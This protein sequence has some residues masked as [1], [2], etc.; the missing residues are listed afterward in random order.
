MEILDTAYALLASRARSVAELRDRLSRKGHP[1]EAVDACVLEL[2][3]RGYLDDAAFAE[4]F[5]RERVRLRPKGRRALLAE[6]RA[7][8]VAADIARVA[9]ERAWA[10]EEVDEAAL[11]LRAARA[12]ARRSLGGI[13]APPAG[14]QRLRLRHCLHAH[15]A[16]RGF[17]IE[18][19]R[20][21]AEDVLS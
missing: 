18:A 7:K 11:A 6:L 17:T 5:V 21:A 4:S 19:A 10:E 3:R 8:G 1:D 14:D 16:R 9:V 13:A 15:L 20:A 2:E 12:W